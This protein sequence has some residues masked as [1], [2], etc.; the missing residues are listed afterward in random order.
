MNRNFAVKRGLHRG[1][2][3]FPHFAIRKDHIRSTEESK[4]EVVLVVLFR[5][6]IHVMADGLHELNNFHH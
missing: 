4:M 2:V 5:E 1:G 3:S 6:S